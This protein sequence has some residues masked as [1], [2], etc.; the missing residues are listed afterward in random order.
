M[1][2]TRIGYLCQERSGT[3]LPLWRV[4]WERWRTVRKEPADEHGG[5]RAEKWLLAPI[6]DLTGRRL[7]IC[8][9]NGYILTREQCEAAHREAATTPLVTIHD[10]RFPPMPHLANLP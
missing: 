4:K 9:K 7:K 2:T 8:G 1:S 5:A 3:F 10:P 6:G